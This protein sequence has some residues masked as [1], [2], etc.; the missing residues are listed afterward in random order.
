MV[1]ENQMKKENSMI[2]KGKKKKRKIF[3]KKKPIVNLIN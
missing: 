2:E 1:K 3:I